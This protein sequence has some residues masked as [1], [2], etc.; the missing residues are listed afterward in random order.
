M[1]RRSFSEIYRT[2]SG[3][4]SMKWGH[5]F[6]IYD[7]HFERFRGTGPTVLEVGIRKGGSLQI[8]R[9][10]FGD[11]AR[12]IGADIDPAC[13]DMETEGFE[14]FIGDQGKAAFLAEIV[15]KTGPF[16]IVIDDGSHRM[17]DLRASFA[18]LFP[19]L[20][21]GGLYL[22]E[23]THTCYMA[24]YGG[25]YLRPG[26]FI[27]NAK[28]IVDQMHAFH[29]EDRSAFAPNGLTVTVN[30]VHFY[31]SIVVIEKRNRFNETTGAVEKR[32]GQVS[33]TG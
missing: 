14:V 12:V 1:M 23:D 33:G 22:V 6:E 32:E 4:P 16:D 15:E 26:S 11:G 29:S 8:W 28:A 18:V 20:K 13:R 17:E 2:H 27:E 25:G 10:Y 31:D 24:E 9:E 3:R 21:S 5:Y 7:A 30:A 19:A